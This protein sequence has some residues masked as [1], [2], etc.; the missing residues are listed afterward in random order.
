MRYFILSDK[1]L[2]NLIIILISI[3]AGYYIVYPNNYFWFLV[4][5][6][7]T[8]LI[9]LKNSELGIFLILFAVSFFDALYAHTPFPRQLSWLPEIIIM[10]LSIK[11][12]YI[13]SRY[14]NRK[15]V[16]TQS[17]KFSFT[18]LILLISFGIVSG[19]HSGSF[20]II[21]LLGFRNYFKYILLF[22]LMCYLNFTPNFY[23]RLLNYIFIIAAV[24]PVASIL[25]YHIFRMPD[26]AGGTF[27]YH[28]TG[29][30]AIFVA[31]IYSFVLGISNYNKVSFKYWIL[32]ASLFI[33]LILGSSRAGFF[34]IPLIA[35]FHL[36]QKKRDRRTFFKYIVFI[37]L[38]V[39]VYIFI[40][41]FASQSYILGFR[42]FFEDPNLIILSQSGYMERVN[43]I[44]RLS[45]L[46]YVINFLKD[47]PFTLLFGL[48]PGNASPSF[49]K[50]FTG[51][52]ADLPYWP[53]SAARL[54]LEYGFIGTLL[55]FMMLFHVYFKTNKII[56]LIKDPYW[57]G[58]YTG[59][60]GFF[61]IYII[62]GLVYAE[63]ILT[64][65]LSFIFWVFAS[66][67]FIM[68]QIQKNIQK[69]R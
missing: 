47:N 49:F 25:E 48:G 58:I 8:I 54:L 5:G 11:V 7:F 38:S 59:F 32:L 2:F 12:L 51:K 17:L 28:S 42:R 31:S 30:M 50:D 4:V 3:L 66:S 10:V 34:F 6:G 21:T 23:K 45:T 62:A 22:F 26:W 24:Q 52:Y 27:G 44:G 35:L 64:D 19:I 29:T 16:R 20:P 14:F 41:N 18:L 9:I 61:L 39:P 40:V 46:P 33:P 57:K 63:V 60:K 36:F 15:N 67:V 37:A 68:E 13:Y 53:I 56:K 65:I 43:K 55:Y 69:L 1:V